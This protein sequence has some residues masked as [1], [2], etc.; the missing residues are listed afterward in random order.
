MYP[1]SLLV[2]VFQIVFGNDWFG[3][4]SL[5]VLPWYS[6]PEDL[7]GVSN[8]VGIESLKEIPFHFE[9]EHS[10]YWLLN[11]EIEFLKREKLSLNA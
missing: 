1:R 2:G 7:R 9:I 6:E 4:E 5:G 3:I 11:S 8:L 10:R